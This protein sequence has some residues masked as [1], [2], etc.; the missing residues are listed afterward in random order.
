MRLKDLFSVPTG[1]KITEKHLRRVLVSSICS[2]LLSMGCLVSVTWAWFVVSI[3]NT[4]NVIQ[5]G[6][7]EIDVFVDDVRGET[8]LNPSEDSHIVSLEHA[9]ETDDLDQKSILYAV[10]TIVPD[11]EMSSDEPFSVYTVLGPEKDYEKVEI[12]TEVQCELSWEASW[13]E[14]ANAAPLTDECLSFL[15]AEKTL[16]ASEGAGEQSEKTDED[17]PDG[18]DVGTEDGSEEDPQTD[19][20]TQPTGE[21]DPD[22]IPEIKDNTN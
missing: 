14:P 2:I 9:G 6:S 17:N 20:Q 13:I 12:F 19:S 7:P 3:E 8:I 16:T 1:Q 22:I 11:E 21:I 18:T 10:L 4:G 15:K 5:I